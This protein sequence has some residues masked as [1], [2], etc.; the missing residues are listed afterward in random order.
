MGIQEQRPVLDIYVGDHVKVISG[1]FENFAGVIEEVN[2]D[3]TKIKVNISM[4]GR[5]TPVELGFDQIEKM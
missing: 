4:F 1:P 5:E 3:K 2:L